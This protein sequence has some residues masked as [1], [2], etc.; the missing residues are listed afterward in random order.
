MGPDIKETLPIFERISKEKEAPLYQT[1]GSIIQ[2]L[3]LPSYLLHNW[4][5]ALEAS[6]ILYKSFPVSIEDNPKKY[7]TL[8]GRWQVVQ[9]EPK[10][11]LDVGPKEQGVHAIVN[12]LDNESYDH[13]HIMLG[14]SEYS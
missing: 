6:S 8:R 4:K 5:T 2:Q 10:I 11:V 13:L 1:K 12:Q 7:L 3:A 9:K 14:F